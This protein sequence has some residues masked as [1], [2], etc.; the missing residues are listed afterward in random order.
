M[1]FLDINRFLTLELFKHR[2]GDHLM[3]MRVNVLGILA[4]ISIFLT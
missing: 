3:I 2:L 4:S 1:T